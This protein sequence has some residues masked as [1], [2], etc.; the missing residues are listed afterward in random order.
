M[1]KP[2]GEQLSMSK[3]RKTIDIGRDSKTGQFIPVKEAE[4]RPSTTTVERVPKPGHGDTKNE[5]P[6]KK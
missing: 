3:G 2:Q 6:R 4:R 1:E 5:P